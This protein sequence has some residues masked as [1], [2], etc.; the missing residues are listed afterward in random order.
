MPAPDSSTPDFKSE[1]RFEKLEATVTELAREGQHLQ[2][3][4]FRVHDQYQRDYQ[5][6]L[7]DYQN[8]LRDR[9]S[10]R[11]T[12]RLIS[13]FLAAGLLLTMFIVVFALRPL[14][15]QG[16]GTKIGANESVAGKLRQHQEKLEDYQRKLDYLEAEL[17]ALRGGDQGCSTLITGPCMRG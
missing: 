16:A 15:Y 13:M 3:Q 9:W 7:H 2:D 10:D 6:V 4:Y 5:R 8:I 12:S 11:R 17:S 14:A 1:Q